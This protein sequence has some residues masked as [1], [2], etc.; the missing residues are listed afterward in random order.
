[1]LSGLADSLPRRQVMIAC[2][3]GRAALVAVMAL[4][5][6]PLSVLVGLLFV[7][8]LI[9]TPFTSAR[10]AL[11]APRFCPGTAMC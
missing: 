11:S 3:L 9:S 5:G 7:V 10:A 6:M 4:P 2:D 1:M 8:T